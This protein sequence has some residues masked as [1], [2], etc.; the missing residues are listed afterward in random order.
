MPLSVSPTISR[1]S[2]R[3]PILFLLFL[4]VLFDSPLRSAAQIQP[5]FGASPA[6]GS[7]P[8][9]SRPPACFLNCAYGFAWGLGSSCLC[10]CQSNPCT[11]RICPLGEICEVRGGIAVCARSAVDPPIV[12]PSAPTLHSVAPASP[13]SSASSTTVGECPRLVGGSC[14]SQCRSDGDCNGERKCC[15]NGCGWECVPPVNVVPI[16]SSLAIQPIGGAQFAQPRVPSTAASLPVNSGAVTRQPTNTV[17][18]SGQC[19]SPTLLHRCGADCSQDA[20]CPGT[21]KCCQSSCGRV[22][23]PPQRASACVHLLSA[24]QRLPERHLPAGYVPTCTAAGTFSPVQCD[25]AFCW[26]VNIETGHEVVGTKLR[27]DERAEL[28][29][30]EPREC[31]LT[32]HEC[33][34][35]KRHCPFGFKTNEDGCPTSSCECRN[36]CEGVS[37]DHKYHEC[38]LVEPDCA[39]PPCQPMPKCIINPC[40]SGPP[41]TLP[42]GV[43]ALC[44][45]NNPCYSGFW[46][47]QIGYNGLGFCCAEPEAAVRQSATCEARAPRGPTTT[48]GSSLPPQLQAAASAD[49]EST[50]KVDADCEAEHKCCFS[51]C[52]LKCMAGKVILGSSGEQRGRNSGKTKP[53]GIPISG[54]FAENKALLR[55]LNAECPK[56]SSLRSSPSE[57]ECE[58]DD[59]C[60]GLQRCCK[61][62]SRAGV[63]A[64]PIKTTACLHNAITC[65]LNGWRLAPR[66]NSR[67]EY[68]EIQCDHERCYCAE[69]KRGAPIAGSLHGECPSLRCPR[70]C[71]HGRQFDENGCPTCGCKNPCLDVECADGFVCTMTPVE[72]KGGDEDE[73]GVDCPQQPRCVP[74]VCKGNPS[75]NEDGLVEQCAAD[76]STGCPH[77]F[78]CQLF[79]LP[80]GGGLC[81]PLGI[82]SLGGVRPTVHS[83]SC[84]TKEIRLSAFSTD[85][86]CPIHCRADADCANQD[87]KCCFNSCGTSCVSVGGGHKSSLATKPTRPGEK[88]GECRSLRGID[89]SDCRSGLDE[90]K[91]DAACP[92]AQMCCSDGCFRRCMAAHRTTPCLHLKAALEPF[93]RGT[94]VKCT[95]AGEFE[96]A[97]CNAEFCWCTERTGAEIEGTRVSNNLAPDCRMRR[98]C[99]QQSCS[100]GVVCPHG[101]RKD[102][103]GC[104]T[105]ECATPCDDLSCPS[106]DF[107]CVPHEVE[108]LPGAPS[109]PPIPRCV[110]N[111]CPTGRPL[112]KRQ[113]NAVIT[114]ETDGDCPHGNH[115]RLFGLDEGYCCAGVDNHQ[116]SPAT[117][118]C[119]KQPEF[120]LIGVPC[121]IR[122]RLDGDCARSTE[123][124]CFNGC[125]MECMPSGANSHSA[126]HSLPSNA[127]S[128]HPGG[129]SGGSFG[130]HSTATHR[131]P[132]TTREATCPNA[133]DLGHA[134]CGK[135]RD[136]QCE[137]DADCQGGSKGSSLRCCS[138]GCARSCLAP[139]RATACVHAAAAIDAL[140]QLGG[141]PMFSARSSALVLLIPYRLQPMCTTDGR[142]AR[143]QRFAGLEWCVDERNGREVPGTRTNSSVANCE[144]PRACPALTCRQQCEFGYELNADGCEQCACRDVCHGVSCPLD[145]VCRAVSPS[146]CEREDGGSVC[147]PVPKCLLNVCLR[148]EL[149][150]RP[151]SPLLVT[152]NDQKRQRCPPGWFCQRFGLE[153]GGYCCAGVVPESDL[154]PSAT[155]CPPTPLVL[156]TASNGRQRKVGCRLSR[157]CAEEDASAPSKDLLCCFDGLGTSCVRS[158]GPSGR[159]SN[160]LTAAV[161]AHQSLSKLNGGVQG[162]DPIKP[163]IGE[164]P[165]AMNAAVDPANG[166]CPANRFQSPGCRTECRVDTD[167]A[168]DFQHCCS[169]GCGR[170]CLYPPVATPC[171]HR[172]AVLAEEQQKLGA[173][174]RPNQPVVFRDSIGGG[175]VNGGLGGN[176]SALVQ[177]ASSGMYRRT[178]C[179]QRTGQCW[180]VNPADGREIAGTRSSIAVR[181]E[182]NCLSP[183]KCS[184]ECAKEEAECE[185][186]IRLDRNG[187]PTNGLCECRNPCEDFQCANNDEICV[188]RPVQCPQPPCPKQPTCRPSPCAPRTNPL[189]NS[190]NVAETCRRDDEC[191]AQAECRAL[192]TSGDESG[193]KV[194]ICCE[195]EPRSSLGHAVKTATRPL[196]LGICP[197]KAV[198]TLQGAACLKKCTTDSDCK[199]EESKCCVYGCSSSCEKPAP[200]TNCLHMTIAV[201]KLNNDGIPTRLPNPSCDSQ[202]GNYLPTQCD[203][204]GACWCVDRTTGAEVVGTRHDQPRFDVCETKHR[205]CQVECSD[206]L[207]LTCPFGLDLDAQGCPRTSQCRCRNPCDQVDC[208]GDEICLLRSRD[209]AE[210]VC[211]PV[212]ACERNPCDR[213]ERPAQEARG[214]SQ[215]ACLPNATRP[216][217]GGYECTGFD[218]RQIGVC[219]PLSSAPTHHSVGDDHE[220]AGRFA[221]PNGLGRSSPTSGGSS[222]PIDCPHGPP[223]ARPRED[224][225]AAEQPV[226]CSSL[227]PN[228]CPSTHYCVTNPDETN[229]VCCATK[230]FAC[231]LEAETG[232]CNRPQTRFHYDADSQACLPFVYAGCGG[233]ANNFETETAC[234]RFCV[235][236]GAGETV[237][238]G[239]DPLNEQTAASQQMYHLGFTLTGP[240]RRGKHTD[241]FKER[242]RD[243][244]MATFGLDEAN[245]RDLYV[246][247]DNT[248][249]F[250]LVG[251]DVLPKANNI[252]TAVTNGQFHFRYEN[253]QYQAEP[254]TWFS[255]Q[256]DTNM[257]TNISGSL[258][259]ILLVASVLFALAV[260]CI[261]WCACT[262]I[263]SRAAKDD[264]SAVFR[265]G[266]PSPFGASSA[267]PLSGF[268]GATG[269]L[270]GRRGAV[271]GDEEGAVQRSASSAGSAASSAATVSVGAA[272]TS[273]QAAPL[274]PQ[275]FG[276]VQRAAPPGGHKHASADDVRL[277]PPKRSRNPN[278]HPPAAHLVHPTI[279]G[280]DARLQQASGQQRRSSS[281][282]TLYY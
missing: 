43:T 45:D 129:H 77:G 8:C 70:R 44:T 191:G 123:R 169:F 127:S 75:T 261:L 257:K 263:R 96:V 138:D 126:L 233:N 201:E 221:I 215:F 242:I 116:Q 157:D 49:C 36:I 108:C 50:C 69:P 224:E 267:G 26:C 252:S 38:Q 173:Q 35:R 85:V 16:K 139:A 161:I 30:A 176:L 51:G 141:R 6:V 204:D 41:A 175:G 184:T 19:P 37:C 250:S 105:C 74:N 178:Q 40:P 218:Q 21:L 47:H 272:G 277:Q 92:G 214:F 22:C 14:A 182:P 240:L 274:P 195:D 189:R 174:G 276:G 140:N 2:F 197:L 275:H 142:F 54:I 24:V 235:G 216:C 52:S 244:L 94:F 132:S 234:T 205:E 97:Q 131:P 266:T 115:C 53:A 65:D 29:C 121:T 200:S 27:V 206:E 247:D 48:V 145:H 104:N 78:D 33:L 163:I 229:G 106:A 60:A 264:R 168:D 198:D 73:E 31:E 58:R 255:Q 113:L 101:F 12:R 18:R 179:N 89:R 1:P 83:G 164:L 279:V 166:A 158:S 226:V 10:F 15:S 212:P 82:S 238:S 88:A 251:P 172:L 34:Q 260:I 117:A 181:G 167:C 187:C 107:V 84:P 17:I 111:V 193:H 125:G 269:A 87:E 9:L 71:A 57:K 133:R 237:W 137:S 188:L 199:N 153:V 180:C 124:C 155:K 144:H 59:E 114:C 210:D 194:G 67:G 271:S 130:L 254:N 171:V 80:G 100:S 32:A 190:H 211:L 13:R 91:N 4:V 46:C 42:N 118:K 112:V 186:G 150:T 230:R 208:P 66:C 282:T 3:T 109:C 253:E 56:P 225:Q 20:D 228:T 151:N 143:V 162:L 259:W 280:H 147:D 23:S 95:S 196:K 63:C 62:S 249:R 227:G 122:C 136:N 248:V 81:C 64:Y 262:F 7:G 102:P 202:L 207:T 213:N 219:C 156:T 165:T 25:Q 177:C 79:G 160:D 128:R 273:R 192:A 134:V 278:G 72:C 103:N 265:G 68:H 220:A 246:K 239:D 120:P 154:L 76:N 98:V 5:L 39:E 61:S 149:L 86:P 231:N 135:A 258:F 217:P 256:V 159:Q 28:N 245:V 183:R 243:Y 232:G 110:P 241:E 223:Y 270:R 119:P 152:C 209:C 93:G 146:E 148:G 268:V 55:S 99:A 90:C 203:K 170:K 281:R 11:S 222:R 236:V 185:H